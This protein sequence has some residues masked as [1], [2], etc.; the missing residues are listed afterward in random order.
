METLKKLLE[1]YKS[2]DK[3]KRAYLIAS[4]AFIFVMLWAFI[5]AGIITGNFNRSQLGNKDDRKV[6]AIGIIITETKQGTKYF[7][8]YGENGNYSDD[9]SVA[10]LNNVLGNFY[11]DGE[12]AMSFQS[13]KGSYDEKAGT[14]TLYDNTYIVLKDGIS[15]NTDK[16][17]WYGSD[18]DTIAE[19]HVVV[20]KGNEL[21]AT[22]KKGIIGPGYQKFKIVGET[23]TK[24]WGKN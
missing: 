11:R 17:T 4:L 1:K 7:E 12:V 8:I 14:I 6:E 21:T 5:S 16:L 2:F 20:K 19:G 18:K 9:R 22:A 10:T 24:I 3:K 13:S 23:T 15:L